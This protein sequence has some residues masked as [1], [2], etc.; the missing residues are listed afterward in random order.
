MGLGPIHTVPLASSIVLVSGK[1]IDIRGIRGARDLAADARRLLLAGIDPI[2]ARK[3]EL[4]TAK[5]ASRKTKTLKECAE[6]YIAAHR[7]EWK[8]RKHAAQWENMLKPYVYKKLGDKPA[9]AIE[10]GQIVE[11][12]QPIWKSKHETA[13]RLRGRLESILDWA[14]VMKYREGLNP[15]RWRGH[16]DHLL[17]NVSRIARIK[18]HAALPFDEAPAR[19]PRGGRSIRGSS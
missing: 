2:E 1:R 16:L 19:A 8:N 18:H 17:P 15:A 10:T 7:A 14:A 5:L 13:L 4:L 11:V 9:A 12:L 3:S 6:A